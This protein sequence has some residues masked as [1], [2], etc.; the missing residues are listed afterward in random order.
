M[1]V[2]LIAATVVA[3]IIS[4]LVNVVKEQFG[5]NGKLVSGLSILIGVLVGLAY[6][7][8]IVH[9]QYAEYCWGGLI[10]GLSAIGYYEIAFKKGGGSDEK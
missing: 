8:T 2:I 4:A 5:L 1:T 3:P 7:F 9:G 10:A 6:A